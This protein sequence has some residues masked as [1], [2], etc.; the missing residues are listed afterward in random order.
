MVE[1]VTHWIIADSG[2]VFQY[3]VPYPIASYEAI[4]TVRILKNL[5]LGTELLTNLQHQSLGQPGA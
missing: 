3:F 2:K 5:R 1:Q 4:L